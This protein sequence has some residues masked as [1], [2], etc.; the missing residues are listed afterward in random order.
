MPSLFIFRRSHKFFIVQLF[1]ECFS[2]IFANNI[3]IPM[4][5]LHLSDTHGQHR[6]LTAL[7]TADIFVHSGDITEEGT[8]D[9]VA[10]FVNWMRDLP[11]RHKIFVAG[12]HDLCLHG[13]LEISGMDENAHYLYNSGIE[14]DGFYFYGV[15]MFMQDIVDENYDAR[16][17][18]IPDKTD[19]LI[20][21]DTPFG[22]LDW[23]DY[24][25]GMEHRGNRMLRQ[26]VDEVAPRYHLFGHE[27]TTYGTVK[28]GGTVFSNAALRERGIVFAHAPK[29]FEV[30][31]R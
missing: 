9:E 7:P 12:N 31:L 1:C 11:Y 25:R 23:A 19:I 30:G 6:K 2:C 3:N 29:V 27:H 21:H 4:R 17:T 22:I 28:E 15:P 18:K 10:D 20:T 14:I 5:I 13:A 16:F 26:R 8:W 24:G